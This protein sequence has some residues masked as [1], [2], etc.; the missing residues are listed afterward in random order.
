MKVI[1]A[2][3]RPIAKTSA[4]RKPRNRLSHGEDQPSANGVAQSTK[5]SA[6]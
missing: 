2:R 5:S 1:T 3:N 4:V 6:P